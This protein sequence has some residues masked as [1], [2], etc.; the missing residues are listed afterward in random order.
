MGIKAWVQARRAW[1]DWAFLA[2]ASALAVASTGWLAMG[3]GAERGMALAGALVGFAWLGLHWPAA[4]RRW[5]TP[6][7]FVFGCALGSAGLLHSLAAR[8]SAQL[9]WVAV[10]AVGFETG[11]RP[12]LDQGQCEAALAVMR[13]DLDTVP[14][15]PALSLVVRADVWNV[16][17]GKGC[18]SS[19][20]VAQ[21][22]AVFHRHAQAGPLGALGVRRE[23]LLERL[24]P[25]PGLESVGRND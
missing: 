18:A 2:P 15:R 20:E 9:D 10:E 11:L 21:A 12:L 19:Q 17:A 6:A 1:L 14:L 8:D 7:L 4:S 24:G 5:T 25:D 22:R 23:V 13:A 16:A 3:V